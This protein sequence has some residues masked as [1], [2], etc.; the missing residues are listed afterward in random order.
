MSEVFESIGINDSL[1]KFRPRSGTA[2]VPVEDVKINVASPFFQLSV[3]A[4]RVLATLWKFQQQCSP[5]FT[6]ERWTF[7]DVPGSPTFPLYQRGL[8]ELMGKSY[9]TITPSNGH[10]MLTNE[11][12]RFCRENSKD[13]DGYPDVYTSFQPA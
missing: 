8:S 12:I 5:N 1:L 2:A 10:A 3:D 6:N 9:V 4:R 7:I 13:I 11:G